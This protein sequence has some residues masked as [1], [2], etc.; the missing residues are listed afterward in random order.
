VSNGTEAETRRPSGAGPRRIFGLVPETI[1]AF[2]LGAL[3]VLTC[4]DVLG[5]ELLNAPV[6]GT[7][8]LTRIMMVVLTLMVLPVATYRE[9]HIAVDLIDFV[10]PKRLVPMREAIINLAGGIFLAVMS[11]RIHLQ[12]I[13]DAKRFRE[14][15]DLGV[16]IAPATHFVSVLIGVTALVMFVN[17]GRHVVK[18]IRGALD[19]DDETQKSDFK[20]SASST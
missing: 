1:S 11:W 2:L 15:D 8:D 16:S 9:E 20:R 18:Q 7:V 17:F 3:V 13:E 19:D 5:R 6:P 10:Y 4:A 12:G 14:Y